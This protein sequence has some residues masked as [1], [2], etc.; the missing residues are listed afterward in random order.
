MLKVAHIVTAYLSAITIID[1]KLRTLNKFDDL[2]VTVISS[3]P[4]IVDRRTPAVR[5]IQVEIARSIKPLAD[6]KGTWQLYKVLKS[7]KFD[8][9]H[10]HTAK[11]GFI[12]AV[13]AKMARIPLICHTYHGLPFFEGQNRIAYQ[14]YR[15]LEKIACK[16]RDYI[17]TQ[18]KRDLPKC[19]KLVSDESR[20]SI[21]RT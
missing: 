15:L 1:S 13:A 9:V 8:V 10:S 2:D 4:K 14:I 20:V 12:T 6:L 5:H 19:V 17:F 7:E 18:N 11:A 3:S 21:D 16:F